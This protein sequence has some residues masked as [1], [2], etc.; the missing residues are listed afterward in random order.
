MKKSTLGLPLE[1]KKLPA[2]FDA[3]CV[4]EDTDVKNAVIESLLK[5]HKVET[6]LD[7]TCGTG[8][9]VFFLAAR[10]YTVVGADFSPALLEIAKKRAR[11]EKIKVKCIE[12]DMRTLKVGSFDAVIT[13]FNAIGHL[14]KPGFEKAIKN[15]YQNLKAGGIYMFDILN[16]EAMTDKTV[17]NLS[18]SVHKKVHDT[19]FYLAQCSTVNRENGRLTSYEYYLLQKNAEKPQR[20]DNTFSLQLYTAQEL[21]DMLAKNGFETIGQYGMDGAAFLKKKT[22][23]ILTVA[24]KK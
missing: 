13:I 21:K 11:R 22:P 17:A 15:V 14:T 1:Y 2:Y 18:Y 9:Q 5:K 24:R 16:L 3:P 4:N 19:Q 6:V 12:G 23:S 7:L 20:F 10:G 8:S